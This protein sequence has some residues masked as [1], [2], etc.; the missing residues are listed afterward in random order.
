MAFRNA[1]R[2]GRTE[3]HAAA[4]RQQSGMWI[5]VV[6]ADEKLTP[7]S[8]IRW[9]RNIWT[10][11]G[12]RAGALVPSLTSSSACIRRVSRGASAGC[13]GPSHARLPACYPRSAFV[14][15]LQMLPRFQSVWLLFILKRRHDHAWLDRSR[16][17]ILVAPIVR[18]GFLRCCGSVPLATI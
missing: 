11:G 1:S 18:A 3:M 2:K 12:V 13:V 9:S 14:H 10:A 5:R 7:K 8:E 16:L 6:F 15:E 4:I 17:N